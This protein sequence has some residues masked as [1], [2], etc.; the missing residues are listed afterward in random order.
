MNLREIGR[1]V[2]EAGNAAS[3]DTYA[4]GFALAER[5]RS[6]DVDVAGE[7]R[8]GVYD[9]RQTVKRWL[10]PRDADVDVNQR[11]PHPYRTVR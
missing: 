3:R 2:L 5:L 4:S 11:T 7:L 9:S 10:G 8:A 6:L 1:R